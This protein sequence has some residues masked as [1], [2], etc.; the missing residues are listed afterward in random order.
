M[1]GHALGVRGGNLDAVLGQLFDQQARQRAERGFGEGRNEERAAGSD[2][3]GDAAYQ[4]QHVL[5]EEDAVGAHGRIERAIRKFQI[6]HVHLADIDVVQ[7]GRHGL[8]LGDGQHGGR[9]IDGRDLAARHATGELDHRVPGPG[10]HV[11]DVF[12]ASQN[13][14]IRQRRCTRGKVAQG[15]VVIAGRGLFKSASEKL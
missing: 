8:R 3:G 15:L 14:A 5:D 10:R 12:V 6:Q 13:H 1:G 7:P 9:D 11:Q 2:L 4:A